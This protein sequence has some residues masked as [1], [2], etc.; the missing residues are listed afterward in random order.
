MNSRLWVWC[1]SIYHTRVHA[2]LN[3]KSPIERWRQELVH[4]RHLTPQ[5]VERI[6]DLFLHRV[7]RHVK[8]DG[9][10]SWEGILFEVSHQQVGENIFLLID[11]HQHRVVRAE[12]VFGDNLPITALNKQA[13]LHRTRQR[14]HA[15]FSPGQKTTSAVESTYEN[16][17]HHIAILSPTHEE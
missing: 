1:E 17:L 8:K 6:D 10:V 12:T 16:Y 5:L 7:Q 13:N 2:G 14:P 11:P 15:S 3:G 9:T 4:V